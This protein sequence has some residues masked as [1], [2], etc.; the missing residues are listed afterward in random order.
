MT[1]IR[2]HAGVGDPAWLGKVVNFFVYIYGGLP[3][4]T[5]MKLALCCTRLKNTKN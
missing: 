3:P 4:A 5:G 2:S 1:L